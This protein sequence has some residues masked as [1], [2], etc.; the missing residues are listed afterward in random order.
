MNDGVSFP[1]IGVE[2]WEWLP[3]IIYVRQYKRANLTVM[4]SPFN[5]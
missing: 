2:C 3:E 4:D 1:M 5:C